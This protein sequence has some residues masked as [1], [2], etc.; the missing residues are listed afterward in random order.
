MI[1]PFY[2]ILKAILSI[3]L[4]F[5]INN[6]YACVL[7]GLIKDRNNQQT[8]PYVSIYLKDAKSLTQQAISNEKGYFEIA[9][10][11]LSFPISVQFKSIG[12]SSKTIQLSNCNELKIEL[13]PSIQY[14]QE[15]GIK[16]PS[17][18]TIVLN[19]LNGFAENLYSEPFNYDVFFRKYQTDQHAKFLYSTEYYS[20]VYQVLGAQPG[21]KNIKTRFQSSKDIYY[22][23]AVKEGNWEVRFMLSSE[24]YASSLKKKYAIGVINRKSISNIGFKYLGVINYDNKDYYQIA[25]FEDSSKSE[26][27]KGILYINTID[28]SLLYF[29]SEFYI[30][31]KLKNK[32]EFF[33]TKQNK[34]Y[35]LSHIKEWRRNYDQ[36]IDEKI[37]HVQNYTFQNPVPLDNSMKSVINTSFKKEQHFEPDSVFWKG[38]RYVPWGQ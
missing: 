9:S 22:D 31:Q 29:S 8:I 11:G 2:L 36:T 34:H 16:V 19:C 28:F 32:R 18:K 4:I 5:T 24:L 10:D 27:R 12:Y 38:M 13:S 25:Y 26:Y 15:I 7:K 37:M 20:Q 1:K 30:A 21:I 23:K 33:Y 6:T 17:T 14:I 35:L 3:L